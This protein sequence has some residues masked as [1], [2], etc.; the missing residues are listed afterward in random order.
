MKSSILNL[1]NRLWLGSLL[2]A[3]LPLGSQGSQLQAQVQ[4]SEQTLAAMDKSR[5][6]VISQLSFSDKMKMR[7]AVG[8]IQSNP[9][10]ITAN[11]AV[12]N[13][14]TPE[15]QIQARKALATLKLNLIEKQ[16]PS[17][18]PVI[19]KIRAIQALVLN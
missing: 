4:S 5:D 2:V 17:I 14:P 7:S 11:N 19:E 10:F 9:Q 12:S 18:K 13:A 3:L 15:A 6:Q 1:S 8:A 16:D